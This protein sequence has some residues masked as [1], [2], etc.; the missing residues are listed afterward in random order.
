MSCFQRVD[1]R[2]GEDVIFLDVRLRITNIQNIV[3]CNM[4]PSLILSDP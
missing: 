3:K 2:R 4:Y 1:L